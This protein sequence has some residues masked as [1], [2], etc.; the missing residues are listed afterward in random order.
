MSP[1]LG[2]LYAFASSCLYIDLR[3]RRDERDSVEGI[4]DPNHNETIASRGNELRSLAILGDD[5][6]VEVVDGLLEPHAHNE[7]GSKADHES[8]DANPCGDLVHHRRVELLGKLA[9][10]K[11]TEGDKDEHDHEEE[12]E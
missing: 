7:E 12:R 1:S 6:I 5:G 8:E 2:S 9:A 10:H 11:V 4:R 3:E